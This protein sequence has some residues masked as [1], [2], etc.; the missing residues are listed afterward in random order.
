MRLQRKRGGG[1]CILYS[2]ATSL[3]LS[4]LTLGHYV[5][6][7]EEGPEES[8]FDLPKSLAWQRAAM[9]LIYG[10]EA[11]NQINGSNE[12]GNMPVLPWR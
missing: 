4:Y 7:P 8:L 2:M 6:V 1:Q 10:T 9:Q 5:H 11:E 12:E 3:M